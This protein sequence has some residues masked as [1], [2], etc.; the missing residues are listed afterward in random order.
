MKSGKNDS[1]LTVFLLKLLKL[2]GKNDRIK[3][4][5]MLL[6]RVRTMIYEDIDRLVSYGIMTGLIADADRIYVR[7]PEV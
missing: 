2:Y 7:N 4:H 3:L 5:I 1:Y 6:R